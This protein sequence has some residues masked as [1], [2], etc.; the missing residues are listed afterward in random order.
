[1]EDSPTAPSSQLDTVGLTRGFVDPYPNARLRNRSTA[2]ENALS[3]LASSTGRNARVSQASHTPV[4]DIERLQ[5]G[6]G[7][8]AVGVS[9]H[10]TPIVGAN[11]GDAG[12]KRETLETVVSDRYPLT[13][14]EARDQ[15]S[16]RGI[17]S[18]DLAWLEAALEEYRALLEY[19]R[20]H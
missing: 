15:G 7:L 20:D 16:E 14:S 5:P 11:H 18:V 9:G 8:R 17:D 1:M 6:G 13:M 3:P 2:A 19:L 10:D 12:I 4:P